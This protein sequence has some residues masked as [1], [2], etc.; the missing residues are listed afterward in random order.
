MSEEIPAKSQDPSA[1]AVLQRGL[2]QERK[3]NTMVLSQLRFLAISAFFALQ[4]ILGL[5]SPAWQT[6]LWPFAVYWIMAGLLYLVSRRVPRIQ[7]LMQYSIPVVDAPMAFVLLLLAAKKGSAVGTLAFGVGIFA[8]LTILAMLSLR[9]RLI[10][11]TAMVGMVLQVTL[12][13]TVSA[14]SAGGR[15][16][17]A[18]L[19]ALVAT[20]SV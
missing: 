13:H 5:I 3:R 9:R 4:V 16:A 14:V 20:A 8:F 7:S 12:L 11:V 6:P 17:P 1:E 2:E 18:I 15:W 10:I 19:L